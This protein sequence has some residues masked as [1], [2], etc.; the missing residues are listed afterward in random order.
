MLSGTGA[1]EGAT[2]TGSFGTTT[3]PWE[4]ANRYDGAFTLEVP[5][6]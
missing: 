4:D 5:G 1:Y 2:G 6:T 3:F